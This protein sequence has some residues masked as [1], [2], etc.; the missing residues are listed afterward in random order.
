MKNKLQFL[1]CVDD[2]TLLSKLTIQP[3]YYNDICNQKM[4]D[5]KS[6]SHKSLNGNIDGC[7]YIQVRQF[8]QHHQDHHLHQ[9]APEEDYKK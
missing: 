3:Y 5:I 4:A 1:L 7:S 9:Q 8:D 6:W 2:S